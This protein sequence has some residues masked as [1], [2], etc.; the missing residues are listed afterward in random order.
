[1]RTTSGTHLRSRQRVVCFQ[2][3]L[4]NAEEVEAAG[5][6]IDSFLRKAPLNPDAFTNPALHHHY[7]MLMAL[8]FGSP[9][10]SYQD[11]ILP[12]Y[13]LIDEVR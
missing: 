2:L 11:T 1:M 10:P 13:T 7:S 8:A 9:V 3:N 12:D 4:A 6:I 5:R